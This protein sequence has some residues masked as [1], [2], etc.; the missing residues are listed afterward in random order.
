MEPNFRNLNLDSP[1][2]QE[3]IHLLLSRRNFLGLSVGA[4]TGAIALSALQPDPVQSSE[5]S[6]LETSI[7]QGEQPMTQC[8]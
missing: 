7:A 1:S 6:I 4:F 3:F 2:V 8:H 5:A